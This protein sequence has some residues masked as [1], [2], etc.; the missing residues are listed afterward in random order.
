MPP[1]LIMTNITHPVIFA[2]AI[3]GA[4]YALLFLFPIPPYILP[5]PGSIFWTSLNQGSYFIYHSSLTL[6]EAFVGFIFA[7]VLGFFM[8]AVFATF[9]FLERMALPYAIASQAIPI[10]AIAPLFN[11]WFGTGLAS[12]VAMATVLCFFPLVV[13]TTKGLRSASEQHLALMQ[14][15]GSTKWQIFCKLRFPSCLPYVITGMKV[16]AALAMIGAIVAEYA[17]AERGIGYVITQATYRTDTPQLFAG[18]I[19]SAMG[20]LLIFGTVLILDKLLA[21]YTRNYGIV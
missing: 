5:S 3:I 16:S 15:Y 17:G 9:G 18:I 12:K 1:K 10:V 14:I 8:G 21:K 13:N 20:G 19:Y 11:L 7:V 4:W 2:V 6:F